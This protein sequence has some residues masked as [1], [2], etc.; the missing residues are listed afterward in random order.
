M[1]SKYADAVQAYRAAHGEQDSDPKKKKKKTK[2]GPERLPGVVPGLAGMGLLGLGGAY[3]LASDRHA[4]AVGDAI[5]LHGTPLEGGETALT[6]YTNMLSPGASS[7][8]FGL[9]I[10]NLLSTARSSGTLMKTLGVPEGYHATHPGSFVDSEMHYDQ[11]R[12][13]PIAAY[14]HMMHPNKMMNRPEFAEGGKSYPEYMKPHFDKAWREFIHP[15]TG[16]PELRGN[17]NWLEPHEIDMNVIPYDKQREFLRQYHEN[18]P[19][20][21]RAV[22]ERAENA[23]STSAGLEANLKN[24]KPVA[25]HALAARQQLKQLGLGGLGASAG[26]GLGH[27]LMRNRKRKHPLA[28]WASVLGGAGLGGAASYFGSTDQGRQQAAG[29]LDR[30]FAKRALDATGSREDTLRKSGSSFVPASKEA[31]MFNPPS[32]RGFM[33]SPLTSNR[34]SATFPAGGALPAKPNPL[35]G[36]HAVPTMTADAQGVQ[37]AMA[38]RAREVFF[39]FS[40]CSLK[41]SAAGEGDKKFKYDPA[42]DAKGADAFKSLDAYMK[43]AGLNSFQANFFGRLIQAG[44]DEA[45][46]R[47]ATKLASERFGREVA[48][49]LNSGIEKLASGLKVLGGL[50]GGVAGVGKKMLPAAKKW[51]GVR[52]FNPVSGVQ[53]LTK[54]Y[55]NA[56]TVTEGLKQVGGRVGSR[57]L[58]GAATGALNPYTG[59]GTGDPSQGNFQGDNLKN[60]LASTAAGAVGSQLGGRGV[61]QLQRR[62]LAGEGI[63]MGFGMGGELAA[64]VTGNEALSGHTDTLSRFGYLGGAALPAKVKGV[65]ASVGLRGSFSGPM[66]YADKLDPVN[67]AMSGAGKAYRAGGLPALAHA[68]TATGALAAG[69]GGVYL[70]GKAHEANQN[71]KAMTENVGQ[72][73]T[74]LRSDV[75]ASL[76]PVQSAADK[77]NGLFSGFTGENRDWLVPLLLGGLGA[78]GGYMLGGGAGAALGGIGLPLIQMLMKNPQLLSSMLNGQQAPPPVAPAAAQPE[79]SAA[80]VTPNVPQ[81]QAAQQQAQEDSEVQRQLQEPVAPVNDQQTEA[82]E[83]EIVRQQAQQA[84]YANNAPAMSRAV[85][86]S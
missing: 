38:K 26:G 49:E 5:N 86:Q 36:S 56:S 2:Q 83:N 29:L 9:S 42:A 72:Q 50:A 37:Q 7:R 47:Q 27:L 6:R 54:S 82:P 15:Q 85:L 22:K 30:L 33:P 17:G 80:P 43:K 58:T 19:P 66:G 77:A 40:E 84:A 41:P 63:G 59:I 23:E 28:Y 74:G 45:Q 57:A 60:L 32:L 79:A 35:S 44:L 75:N 18:L 78:G 52:S 34:Y 65:P 4:Q 76:A 55:Q 61:Q 51:T 64:K 68:A 3:G 71:L 10:G 11:F 20:E 14:Q 48:E 67:L 16:I 39:K 53:D 21:V 31:S 70:A 46:L 62:A 24:Y 12:K 1:H 8:P 73:M 13:G 25:Q 81:Q 69:G